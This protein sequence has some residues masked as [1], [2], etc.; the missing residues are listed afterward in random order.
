MLI[1][2]CSRTRRQVKANAAAGAATAIPTTSA[3]GGGDYNGSNRNGTGGGAVRQA[4]CSTLAT[5]LADFYRLMA[6][7]EVHAVQPMPTPGDMHSFS[8]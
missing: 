4:L 3:Q 1:F 7:L 5:E 8:R 6:V 2:T